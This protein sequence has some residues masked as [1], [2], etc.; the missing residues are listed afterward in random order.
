MDYFDLYRCENRHCK[1]AGILDSEP[2]GIPGI[3]EPTWVPCP[4]C[5]CP[6]DK[7]R[8]ADE[9]DILAVPRLT[10]YG[11]LGPVFTIRVDYPA[12]DRPDLAWGETDRR[13][14]M[15]SDACLEKKD[16]ESDTIFTTEAARILRAAPSRTTYLARTGVIPAFKVGKKEWRY[17]RKSLEE[18]VLGQA[19]RCLNIPRRLPRPHAQSVPLSPWHPRRPMSRPT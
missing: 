19:A 18:W 12:Y 7:V 8:R 3:P 2:D 15:A 10:R 1:Q 14:V 13:E 17:S 9:Q 4:V 11:R 6:M 5:G 16:A